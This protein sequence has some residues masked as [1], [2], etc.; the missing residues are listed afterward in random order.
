MFKMLIV[1]DERWER[2]GLQNFLNWDEMDIEIADTAV[3]GI[4]GLEKALSLR[5]DIIVTDIQMPGMDGLEMSRRIR[6][7]LP[8]V[9]IVVLT[10][11]D[12]FSYAREAIQFGANNYVL[13]PVEEV[14]M[15]QALEKAVQECRTVKRKR[16]S[17][18]EKSLGDLLKG[19]RQ[20]ETLSS[21]QDVCDLPAPEHPYAVL[22]V[23]PLSGNAGSRIHRAFIEACFVLGCDEIE[24]ASTV[25]VPCP[26]NGPE[27]AVAIADRLLRAADG[28][29][30][31]GIGAAVSGLERLHESYRQAV[32]AACF[33]MFRGCAG[34]ATYEE[35]ERAKQEFSICS[36]DFFKRFQESARQIRIQAAAGDDGKLNRLLDELFDE[37][38]LHPGAGK[39][40]I[41]ALLSGM[42]G[43]LSLLEEG[44]AGEAIPSPSL[45]PAAELQALTRLEDMKRYVRDYIGGILKRLDAKRSRKDDYIVDKVIRLIE[46]HYDSSE[47]SLT[48]AAEAVFV[49]P[50]HLSVLFK[51]ATGR[52][53]HDY[54]LEH[55]LKK[56][57]ELLRTTR[58]KISS[59][60]EQVGVPNTS[61]FGT[62]FKQAYGMTPGEYQEFMQR[63]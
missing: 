29:A 8:E 51:K 22:V 6:E 44:G 20:C 48:M 11:Y 39:D 30:S 34:I 5:P 47:F 26:G 41:I 61:Y 10:G 40:Y 53:V 14:E 54:L 62:L 23:A 60:A 46:Q 15:R 58:H 57:E 21:L 17:E 2:E 19:R 13:K 1:E 49:S 59:V 24:G 42:I 28:P 18:A 45:L 7:R 52:S 3:D 43:E 36:N 33:G 55:R 38:G 31:I 12:D 27:H 25:I 9:R 4:D 16:L 37:I 35:E 56:A 63:R 32:S 50:N